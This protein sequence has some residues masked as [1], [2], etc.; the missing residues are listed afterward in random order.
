[1]SNLP[2]L[3]VPA[4]IDP[5]LITAYCHAVFR[6]V[7]GIVP[8]R[9]LAETGTPQ[10]K[11]WQSFPDV[12]HLPGVLCANAGKAADQGRGVYIVPC[13][14]GSGQLARA[15]NIQQ[16]CVIV[17]DLDKG[18]IDD[19]RAH[20]VRHLGKPSLE[21]AS[22]GITEDGQQKSHIYWRLTE[23]AT[24]TDLE[25]VRILRETLAVKLGSDPSFKTL[26]QPIRVAGSIHGKNGIKAPVTILENNDLDYEL[27]DFEEAV[28]EMPTLEA[29]PIGIA[30]L[31]G[32]KTGPN[33][34]DLATRQIRS[35]A[36]GDVTRFEALS[37]VIGHWIRN[38]RRQ[39]G[40]LDDA[41]IA[42]MI[43]PPWDEERLHREFTA[44]LRL[45]IERNGPMP[46]ATDKP[47][48]NP[49]PRSKRGCHC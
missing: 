19:K 6:Y 9:I 37:R 2:T 49:R 46:S 40:T 20:A 25:R 5:E 18:D 3:S 1:M 27:A 41:W 44:L 16:T 43:A 11:P 32:G 42:A 10:Q 12:G 22:G 38:A 34:V 13:T 14:V 47:A 39:S 26:A 33:A 24:G 36:V 28:C 45:D 4:E 17:I 29:P 30:V 35:G 23:A 48:T 21:I 7:E 8:V 15:K 31:Q